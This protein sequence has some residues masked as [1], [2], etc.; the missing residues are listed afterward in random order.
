MLAVDELKRTI[1]S[2]PMAAVAIAGLLG[3]IIGLGG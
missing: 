3:H 2:R 1:R